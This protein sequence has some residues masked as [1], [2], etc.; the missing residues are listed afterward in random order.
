LELTNVSEVRNASL[1]RAPSPPWEPEISH[2]YY[3]NTATATAT[4]TTTTTTTTTTTAAAEGIY[5]KL[6]TF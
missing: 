5:V 1:I 2:C 4:A 6:Q 3:H